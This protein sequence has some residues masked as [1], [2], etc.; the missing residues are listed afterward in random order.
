MS[1]D[2]RSDRP[3]RH[4]RASVYVRTDIIRITK[5]HFSDYKILKPCIDGIRYSLED[6]IRGTGIDWVAVV[7]G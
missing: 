7:G 5:L 6:L 3:T 2:E 1:E 4:D